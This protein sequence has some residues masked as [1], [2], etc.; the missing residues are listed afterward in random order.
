MNREERLLKAFGEISDK[1][2]EEAAP[3]TD[4]GKQVVSLAEARAKRVPWRA[5]STIA[6]C[7]V[8]AL[9]IGIYRQNGLRTEYAQ[10][11]EAPA[12]SMV[13]EG[14]SEAPEQTGKTEAAAQEGA[15]ALEET[16]AVKEDGVIQEPAAEEAYAGTTDAAGPTE[17]V[18]EEKPAGTEE[19]SAEKTQAA[20]AA[21][22]AG[23]QKPAEGNAR[24]GAQKPASQTAQAPAQMPVSQAA[25][26]A[27]ENQPAAGADSVSGWAEVATGQAAAEQA[28]A[29]QAAAG[30]PAETPSGPAS[31][32]APAKTQTAEGPAAEINAPR[33]AGVSR[34]IEE[35]MKAPGGG[36]A[37]MA[38]PFSEFSTAA[39]ASECAGFA[40]TAPSAHGEYD[41]VTYRV[42]PDKLAEVVYTDDNGTEGLRI[43]KGVGTED[44]S[45]VYEDFS[46]EHNVQYAGRDISLKGRDGTVSVATWTNGTHSY[47]I[48]A[49]ENA[50]LTAE[51]ALVLASVTE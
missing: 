7:L 38:N 32:S 44:V 8:L 46:Y 29:E 17:Q 39:E 49:P 21:N 26:P 50:A 40:V 5:M 13:S 10:E 15:A 2:I 20:A 27:P 1:Y 4:A 14:V 47:S 43:R 9:S 18:Q 11:D 19:G 36:S 25:V 30:G 23:A 48:S 51:E 42:I 41:N 45:G 22:T 35:A 34:P 33:V 12:G 6:A 31:D 16:P 24:A 37:Q 28:A 3:K